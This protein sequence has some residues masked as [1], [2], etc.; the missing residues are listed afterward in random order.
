VSA[1]LRQKLFYVVV[2][3]AVVMVGAMYGVSETTVRRMLTEKLSRQAVVIGRQLAAGSESDILTREHV[4]LSLRLRELLRDEAGVAYAYLLDP[5]GAVIAHSFEGSFPAELAGANPMPE[6]AAES[7]RPI[8]TRSGDILDAAVPILGGRLGSAHVGMS[9]QLVERDV[10]EVL[11]TV[12]LVAG[13]IIAAMSLTVLFIGSTVMKPVLELAGL[14]RKVAEGRFDERA[15]VRSNDEVG[16]LARA[17][18]GMIEARR[19]HDRDRDRL[20]SELR[21]ALDNVKMLSG[22]IPICASCKKIRNDDGYWQQVESYLSCHT[23]ASFSHGIC[24][25]CLARAKADLDREIRDEGHGA[26]G[27]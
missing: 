26:P 5:A 24:P 27:S 11:R 9:G 3:I 15:A 19:D 17:F 14:A 2:A 23:G 8:R 20:V 18:N 6:G 16:E 12:L 10:D 4:L 13:A 22:F 25:E 7:I 21:E 1:G